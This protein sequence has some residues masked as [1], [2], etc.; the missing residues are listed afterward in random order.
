ME[1]LDV[2]TGDWMPLHNNVSELAS[3]TSNN[4]YR[5]S[6]ARI[7]SP[8]DNAPEIERTG[9][10]STTAEIVTAVQTTDQKLN[11]GSIVFII[12]FILIT[13]IPISFVIQ[14]YM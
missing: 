14:T 7:V 11:H 5:T 9:K 3:V 13:G 4:G 10:A 8:L 12:M 6:S 1:I 2:S